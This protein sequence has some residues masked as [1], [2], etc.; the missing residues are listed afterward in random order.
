MSA[1][2]ACVVARTGPSITL[3]GFLKS[4]RLSRLGRKELILALALMATLI[5]VLGSAGSFIWK[6]SRLNRAELMTRAIGEIDVVA[7]LA[8]LELNRLADTEGAR[9]VS[10]DRLARIVPASVLSGGRR[11]FLAD[12]FGSIV[13]SLPVEAGPAR[14]LSTLLGD[15]QPLILFA[16]RAGVMRVQRPDGE[17]VLATVR[18]VPNGHLVVMQPLAGVLDGFD[19]RIV[20]EILIGAVALTVCGAL[21]LLC[22]RQLHRTQAAQRDRE[23][24]TRRVD[25]SLLRGR[26]GLWDWDVARGRIAWSDSMYD[27]LGYERRDQFLSFGEL[28]ALIHPGDIDL[29][30]VAEDVASL[31]VNQIDSEFRIRTAAGAWVWL[32]TRS[33]AMHDATD[34]TRHLVGIAV[35]VTD[36]RGRVEQNVAADMRLRDAVEAISE[37]FVLW[38]ADNRLVLCNSKFRNLHHLSSDVVVPGASYGEIM[39]AGRPPVVEHQLAQ[40]ASCISGARTL[41]A[42]LTDGRWLQISERRTRDGG[43]VSVGT[44]ITALKVNQA[45]LLRSESRLLNTVADLRQSREIL[46][47]QK[48][49]LADLAERNLDQKAEAESANRSK[50]EFLAKMSHEL[51]TPLNAIINFADIM[52][53]GMFGQINKRYAEYS[54]D[55]HA[56]GIYLLSVIN[57]ILD[58]SRLEAGRTRLDAAPVGLGAAIARAVGAISDQAREKGINLSVC[59]REVTIVQADERALHQILANILQNSV[60]FTPSGGTINVRL[61]PANGAVNIF[62]EDSGIGI[63]HSALAKIGRP[64]EQVEGELSRSHRGSGLGLAIARSLTELHG[65]SLRIRSQTGV[66]T[67]VLVRLPA[68]ARMPA[69]EPV[70]HSHA[71]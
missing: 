40:G 36:E 14:T 2:A 25:T 48:Q 15:A 42:Q 38:D 26:C 51:R 70:L 50:T 58:M 57:D 55:I 18:N 41:E 4:T 69:D 49:Q 44:D 16:D 7:T 35:D 20:S 61:R 12:S 5:A 30:A 43:F 71:A 45:Q 3:A 34:N 8:A 52:Q 24:I 29:Y 65:G 64:F 59:T 21:A 17:A 66:G 22:F 31:R 63:P 33:E 68:E 54:R 47:I 19:A 53:N 56:S 62:L 11:L 10:L 67:I 6:Q 9:T 13:S 32:R 37:A 28:T 1:N 60:K 27:L 46:E 23:R 39:Q